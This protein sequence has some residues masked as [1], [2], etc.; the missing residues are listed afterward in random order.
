MS[1]SLHL[2]YLYNY[3]HLSQYPKANMN[4]LA[5][6]ESTFNPS[7]GLD[8][9]TSKDTLEN[10]EENHDRTLDSGSIVVTDIKSNEFSRALTMK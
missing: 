1:D 10:T 3:T 4:P 2:G 5:S 6:L 8:A 9:S 7:Q